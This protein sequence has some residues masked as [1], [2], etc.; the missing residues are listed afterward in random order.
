V[1]DIDK[2]KSTGK[3]STQTKYYS[4]SKQRSTHST[5]KQSYTLVQ[6]TLTTLGQE[7][8]RANVHH[9]PHGAVH[10]EN[11]KEINSINPLTPTIAIWVQL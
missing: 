1:T 8:R 4:K 9:E 10:K 3:Y 7:T 6:S 5:A 2:Q 11:K